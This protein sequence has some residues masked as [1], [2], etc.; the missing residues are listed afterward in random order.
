[1][2]NFNEY[3]N[4]IDFSEIRALC[5]EKGKPVEIKK[6]DYFIRQ[7]ELSKYSGFIESG[8][9][10]YT[11]IGSDGDEHIVG[12]SFQ[13]D[14]V[15]DYTALIKNSHSCISVQA[16]TDSKVHSLSVYD[17]HDYWEISKDTQRL[18]RLIAEEL[19]IEMYGRLLGFYCDTPEQRYISLLKRCP[20]LP[21]Y[22]TLKEIAS[23]IGVTPETVSN[24]RRKLRQK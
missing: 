16:V 10:R 22:I 14:F 18:G 15:C 6:K 13:N 2:I 17:L 21:Q 9:F 3:L 7:G 8:I 23:F 5:L 11:R 20:N 12:Y 1:M 4:E 24:I 19:F